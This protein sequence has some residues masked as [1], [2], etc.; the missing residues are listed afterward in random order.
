M[1][2]EL[3]GNEMFLPTTEEERR[4]AVFSGRVG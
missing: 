2:K 3:Y 4:G 1:V